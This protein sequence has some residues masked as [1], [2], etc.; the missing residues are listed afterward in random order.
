MNMLYGS[1]E[2]NFRHTLEAMGSFNEADISYDMLLKYKIAMFNF[3]LLL[4]QLDVEDKE[5][6]SVLER[7]LACVQKN[8]S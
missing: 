1:I 3:A 7:I 6:G 5:F 4:P 8:R 2:R